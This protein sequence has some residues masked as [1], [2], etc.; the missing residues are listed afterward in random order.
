MA[1]RKQIVYLVPPSYYGIGGFL[2]NLGNGA[3]LGS[4][5]KEFAEDT[6]AGGLLGA[7][8]NL[9]GGIA[10]NA[11]SGGLESGAG[12]VI[13]GLSNVASAIP[14][15]WGAIAG[16]GLKVVGG[17]T[18]RAFGSK[19]NQEAVH[20]IESN[21]EMLNAFNANDGSFDSLASTMASQPSGM[22]FDKSTVGKDGWF[23]SKA[24][25]KYRKLRNSQ[26]EAAAHVDKSIMNNLS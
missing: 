8:G 23:S 2:N 21:T 1:N 13:N 14:G 17:L 22:M 18:N 4:F 24:S 6:T 12:S 16:A 9:V 3:G 19:I 20:N 7:A 26:A 10:G 15:P 25:K 11:I 5:G